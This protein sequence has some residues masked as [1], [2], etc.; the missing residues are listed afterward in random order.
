MTPH[1]TLNSILKQCGMRKKA[2]YNRKEVIRVL[3]I[4]SRTF[5]RYVTAYE[6]GMD[7]TPANPWAIDSYMTRGHHRVR[8]DELADWLER[9]RTCHRKHA[10]DRPDT[11]TMDSPG[12][13]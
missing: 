9:N 12:F 2:S 10:D 5:W 6:L 8:Y 7:G 4:S 1:E 11:Q 3:G 13:G